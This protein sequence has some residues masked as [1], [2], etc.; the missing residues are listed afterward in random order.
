M[1]RIGRFPKNTQVAAILAASL[2]AAALAR[3]AQAEGDKIK[4]ET[5]LHVLA[6]IAQA[7]GG[8]QVEAEALAR[9]TED[10]HEVTATPQRMVKMRDADAFIESGF[11]LE[12]WDE[13]LLDGARNP[14]IRKNTNGFCF[15]GQSRPMLEIPAQLSR[16]GG[17]LHPFGNPHIWFEPFVGHVYAKNIEATLAKIA[18]DKTDI[19]AKNRKDFDRKLDEAIFGAELVKIMDGGARLEKLAHEGKLDEFLAQHNYHGKPL[20]ELLGG[21]LKKAKPLKG[22]QLIGYHQSW[23]YFAETYGCQFVGYLEPKP[24]IPPTPGHLEELQATAKR[25]GA[26]A[27]LVMSYENKSAADD[28]AAQLGGKVAFVPSDVGA[29]ETKD[30][31]DFQDKLLDRVLEALPK[32]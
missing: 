21:L 16:A 32:Q 13:N 19:W 28:F 1:Q 31:I 14:K 9:S 10:P 11:Q 26:K 30:W 4:V 23:A 3:A 17:D 6:A 7:V 27:I 2:T 15:A 22:T 12:I 20:A 29:D 5:T 8:D 25:T 18:P 24:G